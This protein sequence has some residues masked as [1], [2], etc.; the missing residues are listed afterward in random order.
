VG[1]RD[2]VAFSSGERFRLLLRPERAA[3]GHVGARVFLVRGAEVR[4]WQTPIDVSSE[5]AIR[6]V[7]SLETLPPGSAG[8]WDL[9]VVVG[10]PDALPDSPP[11]REGTAVQVLRAKVRF[12]VP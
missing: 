2:V 7:T 6:I 8:L 10:D 1:V 4:R 9:V 12:E 5:G 3:I 11:E